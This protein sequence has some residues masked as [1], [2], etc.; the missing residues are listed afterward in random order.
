M[1]RYYEALLKLEKSTQRF[2]SIE[3][4]IEDLSQGVK[5][6]ELSCWNVT[7]KTKI[8]IASCEDGQPLEESITY[9]HADY[10]EKA[11][12]ELEERYYPITRERI[13]NEQMVSHYYQRYNQLQF[14]LDLYRK[15]QWIKNEPSQLSLLSNRLALEAEMDPTELEPEEE[16]ENLRHEAHRQDFHSLITAL[17]VYFRRERGQLKCV[18]KQF[19][20]SLVLLVSD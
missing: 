7:T 13:L 9:Q 12:R 16:T 17:F 15:L 8:K 3:K 1:N 19:K 20:Q 4:V 10:N 11:V 5:E 6:L 18:S 14:E 2:N